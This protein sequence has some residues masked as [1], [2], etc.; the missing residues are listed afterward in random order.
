MN[1]K[2]ALG[3]GMAGA[4]AVSVIHETIRRIIPDSPRMDLLGM[5][6][7]SKVMTKSGAIPPFGNKLF[8]SAMIGDIISNTIYYSLAGTNKPKNV[9]VRG[10]I[11]GAAAGAGAI[12]L[13]KPLGLKEE[14]SNRTT[15]TKVMTFGLYLL[16]GII[17]AAVLELSKKK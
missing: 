13:P 11:L 12:M 9:W 17:T 6:A 10:V 7:I 5:Q 1:I 4:V 14:Y 3:S 15:Q 2:N 16:G 8:Y